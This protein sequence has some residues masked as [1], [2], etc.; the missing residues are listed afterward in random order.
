VLFINHMFH[1]LGF[2]YL[3][4]VTLAVTMIVSVLILNPSRFQP[5]M[6]D[7]AYANIGTSD[8]SDGSNDAI[9]FSQGRV[10]TIDN[11]GKYIW[12]T[13]TRNAVVSHWSWSN[14]EGNNWT[15]GGENYSFLVRGSVAYDKNND[16]LHVIW[17]AADSADGIIYRRYGITRD[18]NN[19]I[20]NIT[21]EDSGN[22]NLQLD[23]SSSNLVEQP[24][25]LWVDDGT[26]NGI[27]VA[28]W[29]KHGSGINEARASMRN[30]S[31]S[32]ADGIGSNWKALDGIADTFSND[33]PL[34]NA[35]KIY[36][37]TTGKNNLSADIRKGNGAKKD[38]MYVF[39]SESDSASDDVVL[40]YS[41]QWNSTNKNWSGGWQSPITVGAMNTASGYNLKMQL[42]SKPVLD[43]QNDRLYIGW[44]RWKDNTAGDT[45]SIAYLDSTN[46]PSTTIDVYSA[47]GTHTYAPTFDLA[48]DS[49]FSNV[50]ISFIESTT[51]GDNGSIDYKTFDGTTLSTSSRFYTSPGGADGEDGSADIP[52]LFNERTNNKLLFA[53]RVNGSLP[54][55]FSTPHSIYWGYLPLSVP[56]P[57]PTTLVTPTNTITTTPTVLITPTISPTSTISITT[58]PTN[59]KILPSNIK[60]SPVSTIML[61]N[62]PIISPTSTPV[63][64][65]VVATTIVAT[66]TSKPTQVTSITKVPKLSKE[67]SVLNK[68]NQTLFNKR[69]T[70]PFIL[71]VLA[72][73]TI[74]IIYRRKRE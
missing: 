66:A 22:I 50:Y 41:A 19:D 46:T 10:W 44:A 67:N 34:V 63:E 42:I 26:A 69:N 29:S 25:A 16:K 47:N 61:E 13:Q 15:Q 56:T 51:N 73:I 20:T 11:F 49:V 74:V 12:L 72:G 4:L 54:P 21:R 27:L 33:A 23:V 35:D 37:D 36:S 30:L 71:V 7:G 48:Y 28:L 5:V 58:S 9:N 70:I 17:A 3:L 39:I 18:I 53:F 62:T 52:I 68:L 60:N 6:A 43:T 45:V 57:T 31:L 2:R 8:G 65:E 1:K 14:D 55:T 24:V 64:Q 32:A 40:A 59:T 38:D